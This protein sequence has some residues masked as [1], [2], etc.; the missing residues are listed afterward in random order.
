MFASADLPLEVHIRDR[1]TFSQTLFRGKPA[2]M[3]VEPV[4]ERKLTFI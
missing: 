1:Q 2:L 4:G 3:T